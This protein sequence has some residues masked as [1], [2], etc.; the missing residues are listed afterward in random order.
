MKLPKSGMA[1]VLEEKGLDAQAT[2][3]PLNELT[4]PESMLTAIIH[5]G[6]I[7]IEMCSNV[8]FQ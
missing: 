5:T 7:V 2:P 3:D 8:F 1:T 6:M 4:S